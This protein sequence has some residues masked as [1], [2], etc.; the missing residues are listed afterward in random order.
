MKERHREGIADARAAGRY[1]GRKPT[2]RGK[3]ADAVKMFREGQRVS[4]GPRRSGL[5]AQASIGLWQ[6]LV[7]TCEFV[8]LQVRVTPTNRRAA[9]GAP[10]P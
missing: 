3:A 5:G 6:T 10:R 2:A 1:K 4:Q 9:S 8:R 7:S